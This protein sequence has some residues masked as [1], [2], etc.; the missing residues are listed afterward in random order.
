VEDLERRLDR[1]KKLLALAARNP[2]PNE[3]RLAARK[4]F[5]Y[6][7]ANPLP[8]R[9]FVRKG[10][11]CHVVPAFDVPAGSNAAVWLT[12][13]ARVMR[14]DVPMRKDNWFLE[15]QR[16]KDTVLAPEALVLGFFMYTRF[17]YT[18]FVPAGTVE[19]FL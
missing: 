15:S 4:A 18:V 10:T 17:G 6:L 11:T 14:R 13:A 3:S 5:E 2:N 12:A 8:V 16:I 7:A 19:P 1:L 9:W